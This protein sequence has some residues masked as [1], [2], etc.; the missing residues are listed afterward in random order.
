MTRIPRLSLLASLMACAGVAYADIRDVGSDIMP[1]GA[2]KTVEA[3]RSD[4]S[5]T[6][7]SVLFQPLAE[8]RIEALKR[9]N[10]ESGTRRVQVGI[11]RDT[12][13]ESER[14][15]LAAMNW[16]PVA[17][18]YVAR[19]EVVSPG[20]N[21]L[22]VALTPAG[23]PDG[24]EIRTAGD[25]NVIEAIT[26]AQARDQADGNGRYWTSVS[27]GERQYVEIFVPSGIDL[28]AVVPRIDAVAHLLASMAG[29]DDAA[30]K[31]LGDSGACNINAVCG[32][33]QL[34][35]NYVNAKNSVAWMNF[36]SGGGSFVCTGTLLNDIDTTTFI[37]WFFT[38][39]HCIGTQ[40]EANSLRTFWKREAATCGGTGAGANIQVAGG[41]QMLYSQANTDGALLRLNNAPPAG[42]IFAGWNANAV[43]VNSDVVGIHHPS[44]DNKKVSI[45]RFVGVTQNNVINGQTVNRS[46]RVTWGEGT[47]EGGSSGSGLFTIA[48]DGGY[49]LRGGLWGGSASCANTGEPE[50]SGNR[51]FY[52]S[53][54][55]IFPAISQYIANAGGGPTG[56]TREYTGQWHQPA[57]G[58]RGLS[59]YQFGNTLFALWFVYDGQ[60]RASWYQLAPAWT[61]ADIASGEVVRWTGSPWGPTYNPNARQLQVVGTFRLTFTSATAATFAYNVDGVNRTISIE[62]ITGN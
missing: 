10:A 2:A 33:V 16:M 55:E 46:L 53:L 61:G 13:S 35:A 30:L 37:P 34:G 36:M 26:V 5:G 14:S 15:D 60:G 7:A 56:P 18:G 31:D 6:A 20:A 47:T 40:A 52:S 42:S 32:D 4:R 19:I 38:A 11:T 25:D 44:G 43:T 24:V 27:E 8:S 57:E 48:N 59:I 58:G 62:K 49:Q 41:A 28:A 51:D 1:E 39:H 12:A 9:S 50:S 29:F 22:R 23:L 45:G 21:G 3:W 17:A 54:Q